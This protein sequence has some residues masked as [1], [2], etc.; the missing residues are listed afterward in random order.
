MMQGDTAE[1]A[2][3]IEEQEIEKVA[4]ENDI[5]IEPDMITE[6]IDKI[7]SEVGHPLPIEMT[8]KC[9]RKQLKVE[10]RLLLSI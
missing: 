7:E 5:L 10:K 4:L 2:L 9:S 1:A 8:L 3:E 6:I